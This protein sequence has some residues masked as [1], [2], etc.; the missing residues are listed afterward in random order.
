MT[1]RE[2]GLRLILTGIAICLLTLVLLFSIPVDY[3]L[4]YGIFIV[5]YVILGGLLVS[6]LWVL[7]F[8]KKVQ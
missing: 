7:P 4:S 8:R 2:L 3:E 5:V 1:K 6:L